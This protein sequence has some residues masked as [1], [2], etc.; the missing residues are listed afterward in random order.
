MNDD[1]RHAVEKLGRLRRYRGS[2]G[3]APHKPLL[4]IAVFD[5]IA[6][7]R[8]TRNHIVL[9]ESL[10]RTFASWWS[11]LVPHRAEV[12]GIEYPF[13][14]LVSDGFWLLLPSD[15]DISPHAPLPADKSTLRLRYHARF[16]DE[17]WQLLLDY[18]NL[19]LLQTY[20]IK[21]YFGPK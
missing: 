12:G 8:I 18:E 5:E 14:H 19:Q 6:A 7:G 13:R 1:L 2:E 20:L 17:W 9:S 4:L 16:T 3:Y 11:R 21:L 15:E 10:E